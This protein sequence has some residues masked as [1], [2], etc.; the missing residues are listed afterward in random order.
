MAR[1]TQF[2]GSLIQSARL[3]LWLPSCR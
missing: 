1:K 3:N 2:T